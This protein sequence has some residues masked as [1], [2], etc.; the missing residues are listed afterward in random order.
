MDWE[1][2]HNTDKEV[3]YIQDLFLKGLLNSTTTRKLTK[4]NEHLAY[5]SQRRKY[6]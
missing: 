5:T 1:K 4:E 2:I 6:K 3:S